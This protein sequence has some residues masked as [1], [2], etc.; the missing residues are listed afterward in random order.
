M[1]SNLAIFSRPGVVLAAPGSNDR[2]VGG[3]WHASLQAEGSELF[4]GRAMNARTFFAS[5]ADDFGVLPI[6][7]FAVGADSSRA[8]APDAG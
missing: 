8:V 2:G 7:L 3:D 5:H 6:S 1:P 4:Q